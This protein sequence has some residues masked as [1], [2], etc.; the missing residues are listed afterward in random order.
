MGAG[1]VY[2]RGPVPPAGVYHLCKGDRPDVSLQ[3]YNDHIVFHLMGGRAEIDRTAPESVQLVDLKGLIPPWD[4]IDVQG[5]T[6]DGVTFVDALYGPME[7][8]AKVVCR[9][10]DAKHL[11]RVVRHLIESLDVKQ[12][13]ELSFLTHELGCWWAPVRWFKT[14]AEGVSGKSNRQEMTLVLRADSGFWQSYPDVDSFQFQYE[15]M[16]DTFDRDNPADLGDMWPMRY[17]GNG[18]GY[19]FAD[20]DNARWVDDQDRLFFT[21]TRRVIAG[22]FSDYNSTD[23]D[24]SVSIVFDTTPEFALGSGAAND[25][26]VCMGRNEDGTWDGNG[27]RGRI[28]WGYTRI[29]V[30]NNF[31]ES[32][33]ATGLELFP[34]FAG[35]KYT[36]TVS[37]RYIWLDL[38]G[39]PLHLVGAYDAHDLAERGPDFRGVGFGMQGG[40]AAIT[41]ATPGRIREI[42]SAGTLLDTFAS[43]YSSGL[44]EDWPLRYE[45][46]NDA[47]IRTRTGSAEWIDNAGTETQEVVCGPY[48]DF[49]TD[50]DNQVVAMVLGSYPE[51]SAQESGANDLWARMGRLE[52]GSWDGNGVRARCSPFQLTLTAFVDGEAVWERKRALVLSPSPGDKWVLVAGYTG[53]PRLFKVRRNG[54][55]LLSHKEVGTASLIGADYRGIGFGVRAGGAS[56]ENATPARVR[57]M[58]AGDNAEVTQSGFLERRN[59]GDQDAY[60]EYTIYGPATKVEIGNGPGSTEMIEFG[61]V[62]AGKVV[63][64]R[65]DP[66]KRGVFDLSTVT[67]DSTPY[68]FGAQPSDDLYRRMNGRFWRN[69][70]PAKQ[71]GMRVETHMVACSITGGDADSKIVASLTPLRRY[72]A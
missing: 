7:V 46:F 65:T 60:D 42:R 38:D 54:A 59:A 31:T 70:I 26:W 28:G 37:G 3:S 52:D 20:G 9:A 30:F 66:R 14:P 23:N 55:E 58:S 15:D 25:I 1:I 48:K 29:S 22:P 64:I 40:A 50:T 18:R 2:P 69:Q 34:P 21:G 24:A 5:A 43:T 49:E 11:R 57:K 17:T 68:L 8:T 45:G 6:E 53:D 56:I 32:I 61:P 62:E 4:T 35:Q 39:W 16:T 51:M 36:L 33:L 10:R 71:A 12:N 63:H 13:A 19:L 41:Q 47:Y 67:T 27:I 44:G 72:P